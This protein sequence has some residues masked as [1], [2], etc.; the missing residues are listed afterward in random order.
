[1]ELNNLAIQKSLESLQMTRNDPFN[2]PIGE[3]LEPG[4][5]KQAEFCGI[6]CLSCGGT[7]YSTGP[8]KG[9]PFNANNAGTCN[10]HHDRSF[11]C[12]SEDLRWAYY[13]SHPSSKS[14]SGKPGS[15]PTEDYG[16]ANFFRL[17]NKSNYE[18]DAGGGYVSYV[19]K[20]SVITEQTTSTLAHV[21]FTDGG[22]AR[23]IH[24]GD[25]QF[26]LTIN[27]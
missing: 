24:T 13:H 7:V 12:D 5:I 22:S 3:Y 9:D 2:R 23:R 25:I 10:V 18:I 20:L 15:S 1:M 21:D 16:V 4:L 19:D 26:K 17:R 8:K 27:G 11:D 14:F 6:I